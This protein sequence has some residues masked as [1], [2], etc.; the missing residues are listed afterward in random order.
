MFLRSCRKENLLKFRRP[1]RASR[2][3]LSLFSLPDQPQATDDP[4]DGSR[5]ERW[6]HPRRQTAVM[7][8]RV[9]VGDAVDALGQAGLADAEHRYA[10]GVSL[11]V[12]RHPG[13]DEA[14]P[15]EAG[16]HA[17]DRADQRRISVTDEPPHQRVALMGVVLAHVHQEHDHLQA[18]QHHR[19][20]CRAQCADAVPEDGADRRDDDRHPDQL[21][22]GLHEGQGRGGGGFVHFFQGS[23]RFF[24]IKNWF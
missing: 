16:G 21:A 10:Q 17:E 1:R 11:G 24:T 3:G 23:E 19:D 13:C 5:V 4:E 14:D 8:C 6:L 18:C 20:G 7:E 12:E 2:R 15:D 22:P 9:F